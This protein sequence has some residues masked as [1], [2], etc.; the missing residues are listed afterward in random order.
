[1]KIY[2]DNE[3]VLNNRNITLLQTHGNLSDKK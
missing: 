3:S 2:S 1:M